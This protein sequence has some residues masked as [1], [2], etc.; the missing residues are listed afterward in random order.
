VFSRHGFPRG[1]CPV[2]EPAN[3]ALLLEMGQA[4]IRLA[5]QIKTKEKPG[6]S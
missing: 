2:T 5:E 6:D 4:S 3:K 1:R